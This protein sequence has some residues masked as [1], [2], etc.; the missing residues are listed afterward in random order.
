MLE[1]RTMEQNNDTVWQSMEG[2]WEEIEKFRHEAKHLRQYL[3]SSNAQA[4]SL[5]IET[6][7]FE[8]KLTALLSELTA[9][10][11]SR[12][13]RTG[14]TIRI[15]VSKIRAEADDT[16][17]TIYPLTFKTND[18]GMVEGQADK[19]RNLNG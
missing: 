1:E 10:L 6:V 7:K 5:T 16:H 12:N 3:C 9:S 2:L 17:K 15:I 8:R 4:D 13:I 18:Q 14:I 19:S 11:V